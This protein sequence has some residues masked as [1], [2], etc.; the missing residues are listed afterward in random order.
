MP[1]TA[2]V[3]SRASPLLSRVTWVHPSDE[4]PRRPRHP[5]P[6]LILSVTK[7]SIKVAALCG[8]SVSLAWN[9]SFATTSRCRTRIRSL[10]WALVCHVRSPMPAT[11]LSVIELLGHPNLLPL[12]ERLGYRVQTEFSVRRAMATRR[13]EKPAVLIADLYFQPDFRDRVSNLESLLASSRARIRRC[14]CST[15]WRTNTLWTVYGNAFVSTQL[16]ACPQRRR[17]SKPF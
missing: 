12:Y 17:D 9:R 2:A 10:Y 15:K 3:V 8:M 4:C 7:C 1:A 13:K 11:L 6:C 14:W 16:L 5:V